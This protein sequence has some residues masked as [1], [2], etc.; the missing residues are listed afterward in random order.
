MIQE[1]KLKA[2]IDKERQ[3]ILWAY[4]DYEKLPW[5]S[6]LKKGDLD[7]YIQFKYWKWVRLKSLYNDLYK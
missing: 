2:K 6:F 4:E 7:L 5:Y 1:K 3:C